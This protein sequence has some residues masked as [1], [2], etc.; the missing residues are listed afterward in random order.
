[1]YS[2]IGAAAG[3]GSDFYMMALLIGAVI[4]MYFLLIRPQKKR[5]KAAQEMRSKIDIGDEII[6]AGGIIGRVASMSDDSIVIET[7]SDRSKI[8]V[9][10]WSVQSNNTA[11]EAMAKQRADEKAALAE[12]K[13]KKK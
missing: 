11:N 5:E 9:A 2:L 12:R 3:T 10:R 13:S 6:V 7:G 1:L 4:I 8:R